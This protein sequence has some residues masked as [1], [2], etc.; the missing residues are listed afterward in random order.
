LW[1]EKDGQ[2]LNRRTDNG[3]FSTR[4]SPTLF[5]PLIAKVA[6][7]EQ[8]K[9]MIEGHLNNPDEFALAYPLP[10]VSKNDPL[11]EKQAYWRG[12]I[13]GP[14]NFLVYWGLRKYDFLQER[15]RLAQ[16]SQAI[17]DN[18]WSKKG[19]ISE[20]YSSIT[21]TG[22]DPRLTS[23]RFYAWGTLLGALQLLEKTA[24]VTK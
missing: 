1:S 4:L 15:K 10:S 13:W 16:K 3:Q 19:F 14:L 9:R 21:G 24:P 17:F 8:A 20:N 7:A 11:F 12:A 2:F 18:E 5:Y 22:D 23:I 6:T